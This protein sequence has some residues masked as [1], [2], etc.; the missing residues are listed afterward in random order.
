MLGFTLENTKLSSS[1]SH[2]QTH[3]FHTAV[4]TSVVAMQNASS[5]TET[6]AWKTVAHPKEIFQDNYV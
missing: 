2:L 1:L 3:A 6:A 5:G 4:F